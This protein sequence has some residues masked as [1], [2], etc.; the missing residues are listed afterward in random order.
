[1]E[2]NLSIIKQVEMEK[3]LVL[4]ILED[5]SFGLMSIL[6][7]DGMNQLKINKLFISNKLLD[8]NADNTS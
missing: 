6:M 3:F 4:I 8:D 7:V 1:M 5:K 2:R